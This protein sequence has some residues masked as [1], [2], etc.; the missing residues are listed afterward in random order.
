MNTICEFSSSM[1][2]RWVMEY[3]SGLV[4]LGTMTFMLKSFSVILSNKYF[5]GGIEVLMV[6]LFSIVDCVL[7]HE[8]QE[9]QQKIMNKILI[10]N[11][12]V[13]VC[14]VNT[15]IMKAECW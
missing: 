1:A 11:F 15:N 6:D 7:P 4:P 13:Q 12:I 3:V 5:I 10:N 8:T 2:W 14:F 9:R